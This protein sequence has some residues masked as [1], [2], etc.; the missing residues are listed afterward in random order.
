MTFINTYTIKLAGNFFARSKV[1]LAVAGILLL[2]LLFSCASSGGAG[3]GGTGDDTYTIGGTVKGHSGEVTLILTYGDSD[4]TETLKVG[5]GTENFTF[6]SKLGVSES[7]A[8]AITNPA[9]QACS[10]SRTEGAIVNANITNIRVTCSTLTIHS[11]GGK[12]SGLAENET[13]TLT[14]A[15]ANGTVESQNVTG[16]DNEATDDAFTFNTDIENDATY[17]VTTTSPSGKTCTVD[18]DGI[19]TMGIFNV[20]DIVVTC[21]VPTYSIGGAVSGL[22]NGETITLTLTPTGGGTETEDVTSGVIADDSFSF[23]TRLAAG[24]TYTVTT[25]SPDGKDCTVNPEGIQTMGRT[26]VTDIVVTC[27]VPT[28]SIGGAVSGLDNGETITLTLTPTGGGTETEDVTSGV[29]ADDSFSF[30]TRLAAGAT[31]TVTTTSP[32][33]KDCTVN[34]E[35][36]Q[37]MGRTDVT[38]I[39][40]TCVVTTYP[41]GGAVSGLENGETITLTLTPTGG[42]TETKDVTSGVIADDSFSFDTRLAAGATYTVTTTSPDGKDCTVNPEG[43]QTMGRTD[44]TDIAVTCVVTTYSIRGGVT[45]TANNSAVLI[46]LTLYDDSTGTGSTR[47]SVRANLNDGTFSFSGIIE[48]KFY[49][50]KAS[51]GTAGETCISPS[52]NPTQITADLTGISIVCTAST[53]PVI[54]IDVYS[55]RHEASLATVNV[56][57][58]DDAVPATTGNP[59]PTPTKV[60]RGTDADVLIIPY[61]DGFDIDEFY[62][63]VSVDVGKYFAVTVD[64]ASTRENC[65]VGQTGTGG[66]IVAGVNVVVTVLC[67]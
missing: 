27:V 60:I 59:P 56:F 63:D 32:D 22:D 13:I 2:S 42:G 1:L 46:V 38:D 17:T 65:S 30:D 4:K 50:L 48:N 51:S 20:T 21:V 67:N 29:I 54:R 36:I 23:D 35:G 41:I 7:F 8:I 52:T 26:H 14:L 25:T 33:G 64:T 58:G 47:R 11:V 40:V 61:V 15:P 37:T 57:I 31:Y 10:S 34:P 6:V 45:G 44:V 53:T 19:Q 62:Y 49:I 5:V 66:P 39:A 55:T 43:I 16:D 12:I 9:E 24:A 18:P 3:T 28:Y